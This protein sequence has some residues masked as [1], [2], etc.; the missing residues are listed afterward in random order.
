VIHVLVDDSEL[1]RQMGVKVIAVTTSDLK[2]MGVPGI[3]V[4]PEQIAALQR[5]VDFTGDNFELAIARGRSLSGEQL[6]A[7]ATGEVWYAV[8]A[9]NKGL[10]DDV[11]LFEDAVAKIKQK[12]P[13]EKYAE[14]S[15][16]RAH[17][18]FLA[19]ANAGL[20]DDDAA[21]A[22]DDVSAATAARLTK[23]YPTLAAAAQAH[24]ESRY[25]RPSRRRF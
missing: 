21:L 16:Q 18:Q 1:F 2:A 19:L 8:V 17:E 15:G 22:L 13:A 5:L 3:E 9:K 20:P 6:K 23:Q 14:L 4:T 12:H 11:Q 25:E 10:I 24:E 7:V